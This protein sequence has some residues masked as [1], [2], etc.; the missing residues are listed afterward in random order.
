[1]E[2]LEYIIRGCDIELRKLKLGQEPS[3]NYDSDES[4]DLKN[5]FKELFDSLNGYEKIIE[6]FDE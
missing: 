4:R 6:E 2:K 3:L 1:M 5:K